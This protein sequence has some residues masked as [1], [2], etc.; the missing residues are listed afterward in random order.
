MK[1]PTAEHVIKQLEEKYR[2]KKIDKEKVRA[3]LEKLSKEKES[4]NGRNRKSA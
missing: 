2:T 3:K 1:P 4:S